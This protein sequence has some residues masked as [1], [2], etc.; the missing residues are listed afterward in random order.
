MA[1]IV[2]PA[3]WGSTRYEGKPLAPVRGARGEAKSLIR[4]SFE[5]AQAVPGDHE[6]V[7][8]TDDARIADAVNA[9][10]G[11]ATMTPSECRNGTE[12]VAALAGETG[13]GDAIFV[14]FQGDAL[15]TP[16]DAVSALIAH[17]EGDDSCAAATVA[18]PCSPGTYRHL[19]E[20]QDAGRVGGTTVVVDADGRALY[21]SKRIL[22]YIPPGSPLEDQPPVL[23]HLGLYAYRRSA[24]VRYATQAPGRLEEIEGLEQLRFLHHGMAMH[25]VTCPQ[26]AWDSIELNNPTDLP[27]IEA[28]LKQRGIA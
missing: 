12:R 24:L 27:A 21:F 8:A 3:R 6:I 11:K 22:P 9:F 5:A 20:D 19:V 7:V 1:T 26:P 25:V 10:G 4:R 23:L 13:D 28:I 17:I 15:L 16:P 18:L 2:I 14:N